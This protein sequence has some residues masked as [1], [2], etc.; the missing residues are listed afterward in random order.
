MQS[1]ADGEFPGGG[2]AGAVRGRIPPR[3][4]SS[5]PILDLLVLLPHSPCLGIRA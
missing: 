3:P 5:R 2:G 4:I 1:G